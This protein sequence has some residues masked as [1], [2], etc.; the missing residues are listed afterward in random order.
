MTIL[1]ITLAASNGY[2]QLRT[3]YDLQ[4][5]YC[6]QC[7]FCTLPLLH[8]MLTIC[9]SVLILYNSLLRIIMLLAG[10]AKRHRRFSEGRT[11]LGSASSI[12]SHT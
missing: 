11:D 5:R 4:Q 10:R 3:V 7:R 1:S 8:R 9:S 12:I 6:F 2:L